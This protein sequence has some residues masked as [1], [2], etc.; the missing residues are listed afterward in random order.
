[1]ETGRAHDPAGGGGS[2]LA[3]RVAHKRDELL[4]RLAEIEGDK[5]PDS[6]EEEWRI[7]N[8]L[9]EL[10]QIYRDYDDGR[11]RRSSKRLERWLERA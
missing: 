6:I 8:Q 5:H 3:Q 10:A 7:T 11:E 4:R 2:K 9:E 1:M